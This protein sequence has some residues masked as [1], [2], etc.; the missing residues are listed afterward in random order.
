MRSAKNYFGWLTTIALLAALWFFVLPPEL[1]GKTIFLT[2]RGISMEPILKS[3]DLAILRKESSYKVGDVVQYQSKSLNAPLLHRVIAV[4]HQGLTTRGDNN[5][6]TDL[7]HPKASEVRGKLVH[8]IDGGG[9]YIGWLKSLP[10]RIVAALLIAYAVYSAL[11]R[12]NEGDEKVERPRI[13]E[14]ATSAFKRRPSLKDLGRKT[15]VILMFVFTGFFIMI[16]I[17]GFTRPIESSKPKQTIYSFNGKFNYSAYA[18]GGELIYPDGQVSTGDP[19]YSSMIKDLFVTYSF[20]LSSPARFKGSGDIAMNAVIRGKSG[21]AHTIP[22][23]GKIEFEGGAARTGAVVNPQELR[24]IVSQIQQLTKVNEGG[25]TVTIEP[26]VSLKGTLGGGDLET[27]FKPQLSFNVTPTQLLPAK[28]SGDKTAAPNGGDQNQTMDGLN[29]NGGGTVTIPA[30][31]PAQLKAF[32]HA[33]GIAS[34]R[35]IG[36]VGTV[37]GLGCLVALSIFGRRPSITPVDLHQETIRQYE[38]FFVPVAKM[39]TPSDSSIVEVAN[40][41]SLVRI[42]EQNQVFVLQQRDGLAESYAVT[43]A[44][45]TYKYRHDPVSSAERRFGAKSSVDGEE[46]SQ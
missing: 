17:V 27:T 15:G 6:F 24:G 1:G 26:S 33:L 19:I 20:D 36:V 38:A 5:S 40:L 13:S 16:A 43:Q 30:G 25:F 10:V 14:V 23:A 39:S 45:V 21:W 31:A 32:G 7:D 12:R 44:G 11:R 8:H 4:D 9:K 29:S 2:T 34:L 42:A 22:L 41:A 37:F 3:N 28:G 18:A 46:A 35:I